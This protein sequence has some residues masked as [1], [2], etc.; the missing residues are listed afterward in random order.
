MKRMFFTAFFAVALSV[1][2]A[3]ELP[4]LPKSIS[5][6][7]WLWT[8]KDGEEL[9]DKA[10]FRYDFTID[11]PVKR[12]FFYTFLEGGGTVWINGQELKLEL[13]EPVASYRGHVK[14]NG[15]EIAQYLKP[16]KNVLAIS[17]KKGKYRGF[18]L[19]GEIEFENGKKIPFSSSAKYFKAASDA[20]QNWLDPEFDD[21]SWAPARELGDVRT[22]P[23][24][25]YGDTA[26]IYCTEEEYRRYMDLIAP[27]FD[28]NVFLKEPETPQVKVVYRGHTPAVE[29]NGKLY[30]P[31]VLQVSALNPTPAQDSMVRSA[32]KA[33]IPF[34]LLGISDDQAITY[35]KDGYDF[36]QIEGVVRRILLLHPDAY[37]IIG[38]ACPQP[39]K[40]WM[41]N[42]PDE[43]VGFARSFG[44]KKIHGFWDRDPAPSFAS[45]AYRE[46]IG[47]VM[48]ILADYCLKQPWGRRIV[49]V[50]TGYGPSNDGMP[51]GCNCMP[52]TGKR[53]TEAFRRYLKEKYGTDGALQKSWNDPKVTLE[54]ALVPDEQQRYGS[55]GFLRDPADP[56]DRKLIDYYTCYHREFA[57]YMIAYGKAVKA[58]LPGR[59][60]GGWWGY[61]ILGYPP[62]AVT[63][64]AER[65]LKSPYIDFL[66]ATTYGYNL[67]DG[68]H[69]HLHT[70]FRRYGKLSSIEA[71]IRTHVGAKTA[72][73][74]WLCKSP[75]ETR[76]TVQ[77]VIGNSFFNGC[78]YHLVDFGSRTKQYF[79]D[80]PEALE[81]IAAG[82]R[83]FEEM[84]KNPPEY[85]SDIA[86][87]QD[88]N[89]L[90]LQGRPSIHLAR[91]MSMLISNETLQTLN[92]SGY[93]HDLMTLEDYLESDHE[94]KT[95]IFLNLFSITP[96][97]REKLLKK[98]RRPGI[99]AI[100]NYAPGLITPEGFSDAAMTEL[101]GIR[102]KHLKGKFKFDATHVSGTKMR[103]FTSF[104]AW[105]ETPRV[106]GDDPDAEVL[107]RFNKDLLPAMVRKKLPDG[108]TAVFCS[109]AVNSA[110]IWADLLKE[111]GSHAFTKNGFFVRRNSQMLQVF[112]GKDLRIP[113]EGKDYLTT[114]IDQSGIVTV[115]LEG[116]AKRVVDLFT[117]EEIA[118]DTAEFTLKSEKPHTWLLGIE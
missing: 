96:E 21:S 93:S 73:K 19:R 37:L 98:L 71:D 99:T 47:R 85:A 42:H 40:Y 65:V 67:T 3:V 61:S 66:W 113:P 10:F 77:K 86:V 91:V 56:R 75:E 79:F 115:T 90:W 60:A 24:S 8:G 117:G 62:E 52:D 49:A 95:V 82:K 103:P 25:S 34:V 16:G 109:V 46:E 35:Q 1:F 84:L 13:W 80:C 33:G 48:K 32:A 53:M 5:E 29:V 72:E 31:V 20:P 63:S 112:S 94:Y 107:A 7:Q 108:S 51:W 87:I 44:D 59:L 6:A 105:Y 81:S 2:A 23:W 118:R 54:T 12:A 89:Q 76:S 100:W 116:K 102:L 45:E 17:Q 41:K 110:K 74:Q 92:F 111:T 50:R 83:I 11:A 114:E 43:L 30:Q 28:P 26:K 55:G 69:R 14:G 39:N 38:Y 101:T 18:I 78:G 36:S 104:P 57:D 68:L 27:G 97:Q 70:L 64:N 4:E 88:P 58:A 106:H 15:A 22:Q 9:P